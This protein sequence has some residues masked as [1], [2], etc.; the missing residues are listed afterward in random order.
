VAETTNNTDA[1]RLRWFWALMVAGTIVFASGNNPSVPGVSFVGFDKLAHFGMFGLLATLVLRLAAV[2]RVTG[3]RGWIA[4]AVV[5]AF[6]GTDEWHQS[7]TPGRS[8]EFADWIADTTGAMVAVTLYLRW[9]LYRRWLETPVRLW[10]RRC[11]EEKAAALPMA[12]DT[13]GSSR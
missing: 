13:A 2:W 11:R 1:P 7:Y 3:W 10:R 4:V 12:C 8:V 6:G 9:P 5:S